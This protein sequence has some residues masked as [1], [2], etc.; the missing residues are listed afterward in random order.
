[1]EIWEDVALIMTQLYFRVGH[2]M[3]QYPAALR[4]P[5]AITSRRQNNILILKNILVCLSS[6]NEVYN[7]VDYTESNDRMNSE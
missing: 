1:M 5:K 4:I 2:K 3:L 6:L 7:S